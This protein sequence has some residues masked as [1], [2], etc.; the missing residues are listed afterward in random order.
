V[1]KS[2]LRVTS[3]SEIKPK[4]NTT[5]QAYYTERLLALYIDVV[6]TLHRH[7]NREFIL[8]EDSELSHGHQKEGVAHHLREG[9]NITLLADP[10]QPPNLNPI[11]ACCNVVKQRVRKRVYYSAEEYRENSQEEWRNLTI[12]VCSRITEMPD[13][14]KSLVEHGGKPVRS[15]LW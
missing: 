5:T 11:E 6:V 8:Q 9:N 12:E 10:P 1:R 7:Y 4:G 3:A 15:R 13:R 2:H 14:C